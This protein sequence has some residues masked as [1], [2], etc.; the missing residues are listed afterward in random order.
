MDDGG[1][2]G[3]GLRL[4][5]NNFS[6][7]EV[8]RL[9][10]ILFN[11]YNLKTTIQKAGDINHTQFVIYIPKES[12]QNLVKIVKPYIHPSMKYKFSNYLK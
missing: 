3:S 5:T 11:K 7:S 8:L 4:A 6:N 1:K 12:M 2:V 10:Y 9:C